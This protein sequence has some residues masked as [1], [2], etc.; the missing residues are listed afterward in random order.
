[1]WGNQYQQPFFGLISPTPH[2]YIYAK[3]GKPCKAFINNELWKNRKMKWGK[4]V[5]PT[6]W[7]RSGGKIA[8]FQGEKQV[9][10]TSQRSEADIAAD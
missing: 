2:L 8:S 1:M 5:T 6:K 4:G 7:G 3:W 10:K 9:L